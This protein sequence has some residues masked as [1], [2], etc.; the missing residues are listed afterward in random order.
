MWRKY[1]LIYTSILVLAVVVGRPGHSM[2][3]FYGK[4]IAKETEA[5]E[6]AVEKAPFEEVEKDV[7]LD[8]REEMGAIVGSEQKEDSLFMGEGDKEDE[9]IDL[10]QDSPEYLKSRSDL[11]IDPKLRLGAKPLRL[12]L[13]DC[14]RIALMN[15]NKIQATEYGIDA[16]EAQL[17]EADA[18]FYPVFEYEWLSAPVPK[19]LSRALGSF[20]RGDM[21]WWNKFSMRM[22]VPLYAF[23]K[24]VLA[25]E[26]AKGGIAAEREKRK[27]EKLSTVTQV[28]Q[29]YYGVLLAQELGQLLVN[30][31]NKLSKAVEKDEDG[32]RS[33]VE[34]IRGKVFLIELE[35][36]LAEVRDKEI[37]ALE[38]LRVQLG[39]SPDVAVMVYSDKLRPVR[40]ELR[41][42]ENYLEMALE[43]RPD[44][45][46]VEIGVEARRQ[47]YSLEKRKILPNIGVGAY[48]DI[49]RTVGKVVGVTTT[50]DWSDPMVFSRAGIGMRFD[51][52]FDLHGHVARVNKAQSEYYKAS[53][54][55][56]MAKDGIGL[57][58]RK[59]YIDA[60]TALDDVLRA[61]KAQTFARQLTFLTQSNYEIG[62]GEEQEYF[63]AL[64]LVLM[65]RGK[66]Y[67]AVFNYN[68]ALA[69]L[70]E[71]TGIIP[72]ADAGQG[73]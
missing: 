18:R 1:L 36:R 30:A 28:R 68:I 29:L 46:L 23:G 52:K 9:K 27:K 51:G 14:I 40:T 57:E 67:E 60:K 13:E 66:Y 63:D 10:E 17:Q 26:L 20:F 73:G 33:P 43:S 24:L 19:N 70:D 41:D 3:A 5:L 69:V 44:A 72:T 15:N 58:V 35:N 61:D 48:L 7:G 38:G 11:F 65:T 25:Q 32:G 59:A 16:A 50:D 8:I 39:L 21:C 54:E 12:T 34:R 4:D 31:H 55:H 2:S 49:G 62:V 53:L 42:F 64:E 6:P 22:G 47:Q 45:K 71:K 37:L 56:Y